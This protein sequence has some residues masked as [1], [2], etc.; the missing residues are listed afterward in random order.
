MRA[1]RRLDHRMGETGEK[2]SFDIV[3]KAPRNEA[4]TYVK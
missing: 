1:T 2:M 4:I 3:G